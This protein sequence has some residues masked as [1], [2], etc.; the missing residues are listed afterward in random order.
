MDKK[1]SIKVIWA[2]LIFV[3]LTG[4]TYTLSSLIKLLY[5]LSIPHELEDADPFSFFNFVNYL[6]YVFW[7]EDMTIKKL[8]IL[9]LKILVPVKLSQEIAKK[10]LD[11][12]QTYDQ[13]KTM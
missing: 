5:H 13:S 7:V 11:K 6:K 1:K 4:S 9:I 10:F 2:I 8:P 12:Q 3:V